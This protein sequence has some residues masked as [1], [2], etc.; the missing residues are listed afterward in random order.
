MVG[1]VGGGRVRRHL[2][3]EAVEKQNTPWLVLHHCI[4]GNEQVINQH[5]LNE[6]L[7]ALS[8]KKK[9]KKNTL[10]QNRKFPAGANTSWYLLLSISSKWQSVS[11][12]NIH[13]MKM[14]I[15]FDHKQYVEGWQMTTLLEG[16]PL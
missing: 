16:F 12:A 2:P 13:L 8:F 15:P 4:S 7:E 1:V 9:K 14:P 6:K 3:E 10:S 5:E 11:V